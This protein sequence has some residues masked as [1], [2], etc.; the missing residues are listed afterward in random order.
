MNYRYIY[1]IILLLFYNIESSGSFRPVLELTGSGLL[2]HPNGTLI[3]ETV[4][5]NNQGEYS[6]QVENGVGQPLTKN[7]YVSVKSM[8]NS[9]FFLL[10]KF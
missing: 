7:I 9:L 5:L 1:C 8:K 6:C 4:T 3:F 2:G 10:W